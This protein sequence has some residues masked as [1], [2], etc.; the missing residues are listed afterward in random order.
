MHIEVLCR[1]RWCFELLVTILGSFAFLPSRQSSFLSDI[2]L[3]LRFLVTL[4][5][6]VEMREAVLPFVIGY[7]C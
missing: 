5:M 7:R 1:F 2:Q 6:L 4:A 3:L